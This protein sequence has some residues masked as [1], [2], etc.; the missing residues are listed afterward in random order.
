MLG[1]HAEGRHVAQFP[2][3]GRC[4]RQRN[5]HLV[6]GDGVA[7]VLGF[8]DLTFVIGL[9]LKIG[10][11]VGLIV[12]ESKENILGSNAFAVRPRH[13]V[14]NGICPG[15]GILGS[16]GRQQRMVFALGV[17]IDQRQLRHAAGKHIEI[18]L[19]KGCRL[20]GRGR[21]DRNTLNLGRRFI[22]RVRLLTAGCH[23]KH[24]QHGQQQGCDF[25]HH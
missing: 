7:G 6:I 10:A 25:F 17:L 2:D 11:S 20:D 23:G 4:Q 1:H 24:H 16:V 14:L 19:A 5:A 21:A 15:S 8:C 12:L 3:I 18:V 22:C 13:A 9:R